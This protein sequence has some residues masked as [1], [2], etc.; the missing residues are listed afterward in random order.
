MGCTGESPWVA[1]YEIGW[2]RNLGQNW[3]TTGLTRTPLHCSGLLCSVKPFSAPAYC[4]L[5]SCPSLAPVHRCCLLWSSDLVEIHMRVWCSSM[6][7]RSV[8]EVFAFEFDYSF[9]DD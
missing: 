3:S 1:R 9:I 4:P 2:R 8:S 5:Q 7:R 6:P